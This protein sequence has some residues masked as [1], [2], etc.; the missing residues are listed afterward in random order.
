MSAEQPSNHGTRM[1]Q[2]LNRRRARAGTS[3]AID[4]TLSIG[5]VN[6]PHFAVYSTSH[7]W[8]A[9]GKMIGEQVLV[10]LLAPRFRAPWCLRYSMT[11]LLVSRD[12]RPLLLGDAKRGI[13]IIHALLLTQ[14]S[15]IV[16]LK[17]KSYNYVLLKLYLVCML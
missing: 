9:A 6:D 1:Q 17:K 4:R 13:L 11:P 14:I 16:D 7:H 3:R 15:E 2:K 8:N 5:E 12:K 10:N